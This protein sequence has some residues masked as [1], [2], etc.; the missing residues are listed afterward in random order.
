MAKYTIVSEVSEAFL[1]VL[2]THLIP[3]VIQ[4]TDG[5]MLCNPIDR[6]DASLGIYLY[7]IQENDQFRVNEMMS[8][9]VNVQA[10]PSIYL[11]LYYMI[12]AYS[13][14]DGKFRAIEEQR[15]LGKVIQT[16]RDVHTISRDTLEI[17]EKTDYYDIR[18][19]M[20]RLETEQKMKLWNFSNQPYKVSV[21]YKVSPVE[22]NSMKE[23]KIKRVAEF[24]LITT[25]K[26]R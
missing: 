2:R 24:D 20:V 11:N 23:K 14:S 25:D 10:Y 1:K 9:G 6:G 3:E 15:I 26:E 16:L 13:G 18:I 19:E 8:K 4:N 7:D 21:F 5:I 22:I 12:T 17:V